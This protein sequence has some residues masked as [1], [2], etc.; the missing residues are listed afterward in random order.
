MTTKNELEIEKGNKKSIFKNF[1]ILKWEDA[2][3]GE[4]VYIAGNLVL[5]EPTRVY[6]PHTIVCNK[7]K[8]LRNKKLGKTFFERW[9]CL[10]K[11]LE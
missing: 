3:N 6:G 7:N 10:F 11:K 4:D 8:I 9:K 1:K 2:V 5:N